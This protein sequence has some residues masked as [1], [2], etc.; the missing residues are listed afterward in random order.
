MTANK[1]VIFLYD[2]WQNDTKFVQVEY[3]KKKE[4]FSVM[5]RIN[6]THQ[7]LKILKHPNDS[8]A[9]ASIE[10]SMIFNYLRYLLLEFSIEISKGCTYLK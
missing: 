8:I 6:M 5:F 1:H 10:F 7:W 9:L 2:A 3:V 4:S